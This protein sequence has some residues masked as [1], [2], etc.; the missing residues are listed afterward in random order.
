[1]T[2][3]GLILGMLVNTTPEIGTG[4]VYPNLRQVILCKLMG[5]AKHAFCRTVVISAPNLRQTYKDDDY[6]AV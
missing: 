6:S 5:I 3:I 1:M 4:E 2:K